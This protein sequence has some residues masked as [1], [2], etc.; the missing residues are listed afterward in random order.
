M[1]MSLE[2]MLH[3]VAKPFVIAGASAY[4]ILNVLGCNG[5]A[6]QTPNPTQNPSPKPSPTQTYE[7]EPTATLEPYTPTPTKEPTPTIT[8]P[9]TLE[10][11]IFDFI[12]TSGT[13]EQYEATRK[14]A[15]EDYRAVLKV[16]G[17]KEGGG[18]VKFIVDQQGYS[19]NFF[20][21]NKFGGAVGGLDD[22]LN[23]LYRQRGTKHET[24]H[25]I[26]HTL[27]PTKNNIE[28][29][30]NTFDEGSAQY[31]SGEVEAAKPTSTILREDDGSLKDYNWMKAID[32][33]ISNPNKFWERIKFGGNAGHL[34]GQVLY[35][36]L[37]HEGLTPEKHTIALGK[38]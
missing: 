21:G 37:E 9:P 32:Y 36:L 35:L 17:I 38:L 29:W 7:P 6:T 4:L 15:L 26:N 30:Y 2:S 16:Y 13:P 1:A 25:A 14:N 10:A 18:R 3:K 5:N 33:L 28:P 20:L 27:F 12:F 23:P 34:T 19:V 11:K 8:P 22:L 24:A 31:A